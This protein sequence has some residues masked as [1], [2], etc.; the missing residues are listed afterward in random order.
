VLKHPPGT[1]EKECLFHLL[2][3]ENSGEGREAFRSLVERSGRSLKPDVLLDLL[4]Q[5]GLA[6]Y[7]FLLLRRHD[8]LD[9]FPPSFT[10]DLK[11]ISR[12]FTAENLVLLSE[13]RRLAGLFRA[14]G[15]EAVPL[16]GAALFTTLYSQPGLRPMQDIDLLVRDKDLQRAEEVLRGG[17]YTPSPLHSSNDLRRFHFHLPFSNADKGIRVEIHWNL[18]DEQVI[19]PR[20]LEEIWRRV[21]PDEGLGPRLDASTEFLYLALHASKHGTFNGALARRAALRPFLLD[22]LSG[23]RAIWF[24]D[25]R[26]L[27]ARG[28]GLRLDR[29]RTL[30]EEW[31]VSP[32]LYS[33]LAVAHELFGPVD[34]WSWPEDERPPGESPLKKALLSSLAGGSLRGKRGS[35]AILRRL[36]RM[37]HTLQLRPVRGLDL[38]D[39]LS[40]TQEKV[41][42]WSRGP[43]LIGLPFLYLFH[44]FAG[45]GRIV[46]RLVPIALFTLRKKS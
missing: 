3:L 6:P 11:G 26:K 12:A 34:G 40:P 8:L 45:L 20:V 31:E 44:L 27:M 37:D 33:S 5:H 36:Q 13:L 43:R 1:I 25:L 23:N 24:L 16:K 22:P 35:L 15:V 38:L 21:I 39:L 32:A 29:L 4:R 14:E 9:L 46:V 7:G 19:P 2:R 10:D 17:G 42:R 28:E 41:R 18:A 30:A